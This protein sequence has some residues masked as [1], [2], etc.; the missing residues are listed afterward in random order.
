ML[1]YTSFYSQDIK[2]NKEVEEIIQL[3]KDSIV[4]LAIELLDDRAGIEN[5][6][7]IKVL[8]NGSEVYVSFR[9][10]I[11]FVPI[12]TVFYFD[13]G[14]RILER[15]AS[16]SSVSNGLSENEIMIIPFYK[17]TKASRRNIQF[18]IEAV[19]KSA[20]IGSIDMTNFEGNIII[21]EF[22]NY[23]GISVVSEFQE[24]SYKIEKISGK[25]FGAEHAQLVP[26]PFGSENKDM[27]KE[28]H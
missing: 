7:K 10:P 6:T 8:T 23:Y 24:S 18:V 25:I 28:I 5:F 22:E 27:F 13:V 4:Q 20:E 11:K 12:Q 19:H 14:V 16:Y 3:G 17:E 9:N 26:P 15:T 21:L 2:M 1:N